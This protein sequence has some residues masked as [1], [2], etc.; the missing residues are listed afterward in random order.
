MWEKATASVLRET[1]SE[2]LSR[3]THALRGFAKFIQDLSAQP[4]VG[5]FIP[6]GRFLNNTVAFTYRHSP[7]AYFGI[8]SRVF[9]GKAG[10]G[11][12]QALGRATVGTM[13]LGYMTYEQSKN[14]EEGLQWFEKRN[15]D[16]SIQD[17]TN[18]FPYSLYAL[19]GRIIHNFNQGEGMDPELINSL[20]QQVGPL[21][22]LENVAG[23]QVIRDFA[24][25]MSDPQIEDGEKATYLDLVGNATAYV[26]GTIGDIAAG[27]TRPLDLVSRSI[28][29][30]NPEAG[31]GVT[32]DRKQAEGMDRFVLGLTRYVSGFMNFAFGEE[33]E[34]GVRLYGAPK[35]S[36]TSM[37]PAMIPNPAGTIVGTTLQKQSRNLNKLLGL[38]DKPPFRADSFTSG[39]PEYDA[40]INQQVTPMLERRAESLLNNDIFMNAPKSMQIERVSGMIKEVQNEVLSMLEGRRIG[41]PE[42]R[43]MNERRKLL[44]RDRQAR[45]RAK[46]ALGITTD[47]HKLSLFE[48]E[49]IRRRMALEERTFE[50][51]N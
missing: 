50:R 47:D 32:I 26:G 29:Y 31:G 28:S 2:D 4:G 39:V 51:M 30:V 34:Y 11:V 6:F 10:E 35:E 1:F 24:M 27:Y 20:V 3:G 12:D 40:F 49:A 5:F 33:T 7:L 8:A 22:A 41:D 36:A 15:A 9:R 14:Q 48:I 25:F 38:V 23:G 21:D 17:I 44:T 42:D 46:E 18:L 16:G 19:S 13:A 37:G 45:I 43:L